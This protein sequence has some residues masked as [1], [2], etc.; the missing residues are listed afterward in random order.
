MDAPEQ[1]VSQEAV[2]DVPADAPVGDET[3]RAPVASR[4][5]QELHNKV[6]LNMERRLNCEIGDRHA[7]GRDVD[8]LKSR[9]ARL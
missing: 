3:Q 7:L 6:L 8:L 1:P 4:K 9:V 2:V 5:R